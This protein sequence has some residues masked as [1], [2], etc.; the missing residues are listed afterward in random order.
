MGLAFTR[1][2][3]MWTITPLLEKTAFTL[4]DGRITVEMPLEETQSLGAF[5]PL[6]LGKEDIAQFQGH[7]A[8]KWY[9][10]PRCVV[11]D[12]VTVD[13]DD[14]N[15]IVLRVWRWIGPGSPPV[16][17]PRIAAGDASLWLHIEYRIP[18]AE[19]EDLYDAW[20]AGIEDSDA[21]EDEDEGEDGDE[22]ESSERNDSND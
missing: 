14:V 9:R 13:P 15:V 21:E 2:L 7:V 4:S 11:S 8:P 22:D 1:E 18:R 19:A 20:Q 12:L 10:Q 6:Y 16:V 5:L 3:S 17:F